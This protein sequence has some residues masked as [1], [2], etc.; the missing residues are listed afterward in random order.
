MGRHSMVE[1]PFPRPPDD[2]TPT[3]PI[4]AIG[5]ATGE[6]PAIVARTGEQPAVAD[7]TSQHRAVTST[8]E[9]RAVAAT[10][11][12]RAVSAT[13]HQR[14]IT[15]TGQQRAIS[16]TG[17]RQPVTTTGQQRAVSAVTS[18]G[19]QRAV[20]STGQQGAVTA[21]GEQRAVTATGHHRAIG[22][23]ATRRRIAKW[24]FVAAG[25][26]VLL[27]V[28]LL[29]WGWANNVVDNRAEAQAKSCPEGD[30]TMKVLVA[31]GAGPAVS[32]AAA[33]WNNARTVVHA[34]CVH[35]DVQAVPSDRVFDALTGHAGLDTI[36]GQPAAWIPEATDW[37]SRLA[38]ER[39]DLAA[40]PAESL[41]PAYTYVCFSGPDLEA[42]R[43][44]QVFRDFLLNPAQV[45]AL[46]AAQP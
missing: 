40:T 12:R 18:T 14:A 10:G 1:E 4:P 43:A 39:P 22:K 36:G 33:K 8:G 38:T 6:H 11:Q 7:T 46:D 24:P 26:V 30:S 41:T 28:G 5:R 3:G 29:G 45:T 19:Q 16:A 21:T 20:T 37:A 31:P 32:A 27:V 15:A 9:Q 25:V 44:A 2:Q 13:G 17:Q 42:V 34:H 23:A 35:V